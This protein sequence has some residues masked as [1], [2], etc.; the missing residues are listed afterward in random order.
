MEIRYH[1]QERAEVIEETDLQTHPTLDLLDIG[2]IKI[3]L[4]LKK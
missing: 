4:C 3:T 2:H 1:E